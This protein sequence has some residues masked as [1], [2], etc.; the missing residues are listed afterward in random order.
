MT[1][2]QDMLEISGKIMF[3]ISMEGMFNMSSN[4][5]F[6]ISIED[7]KTDMHMDDIFNFLNLSLQDMLTII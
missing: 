6:N 1:N 5:W 4:K 7:I 2:I 3:K